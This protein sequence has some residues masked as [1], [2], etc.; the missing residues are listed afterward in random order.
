MFFL[1]SYSSWLPACRRLLLLLPALVLAADL[2]A[3]S[4]VKADIQLANNAVLAMY[5]DEDANMWIG[6]YDGLHL[7]NGKNTFVFRME[8]DNEFSLCSNIVLEI[9][10]AE[11]GYLWVTT[12]LGV[13]KFSL[14]ERHVVES[15][16]QYVDVE[17]IASDSEGN[18]VLFSGEDF[19][20][21][22][23]PQNAFFEDV[24]MP[25]VRAAEIVAVWSE[26]PREFCSLG[27]DGELVRYRLNDGEGK[28]FVR[29]SGRQLSARPVRKA[30]FKG[31]RLHFVDTSGGLWRYTGK[32]E[33]LVLLSD[34]S[35][36]GE[37]GYTASTVCSFGDEIYVGFLAGGLGRI[38]EKGG[39]CELIASDYRVFCLRADCNQD[40]LWVGTDGYGAYMYCDKKDPFTTLLMGDM[41]Q[42]VLK[43]V[44]AI[45]TDDRGDLWIGT[46]GDG[47][48]R[49]RD[50]ESYSGG[51]IPADRLTRFDRSKGLT[52]NEVFSFCSSPAR[53]I[54]W[55]GTS[56][57]GLTYYSY[58]DD[59]MRALPLQLGMQEP[60]SVHQMCE[61]NDSTLYLA[62]DT[63]ALVELTIDGGDRPF[64][65]AMRRYR[66]RHERHDCNEFYALIRESD[67]TLLLGMRG[68]YGLLRFNIRTKESEFVDMHRL[69]SRALGD[70]LCLCKSRESGLYCGASSGLILLTPQGD[71]RQ[72]DRRNG[73]VNDMIHGVLEDRHGCIWLSTN[74]GLVQY[75]PDHDFFHNYSS[76]DLRV[77]EFCDDA[78][79][80]CPRTGRLFF[81]GV[82]GVVWIDPASEVLADYKPRLRFMD[83]ELPDGTLVPLSGRTDDEKP[84]R[85]APHTT[86]FA[87]SF[88]AV[89]YLN[90][91]NYE[92]SY[93]LEGYSDKWVE[94]QKNNRVFFTGIPAGSYLLHVRYK[95]NVMDGTA[96]AYTLAITVLPPWYRTTAALVCYLLLAT[97]LVWLFV[98]LLRRHYRRQQQRVVARLEEVQREKLYEAR[99]NF[100]VN[101]SHEL[102]TPLTLINGMNE[103]IA[104]LGA[105]D[106]RLSK[107]TEV[108]HENV[109]GLNELIQEVLD[110]RKIEEEGFGR[111]RIR[112]VDIKA[113]LSVQVHS[114]TDA[115]ERNDIDLRLD[116]PPQLVWNTDA[117][118]LKKVVFNLVSNAMKYTPQRGRIGVSA[119]VDA[120][121][122]VLKV[123]N[124][125]RG[126]APA[127]LEHVF[128][129]YRI[130]DS[131]DRNMYTDSTSRNGLGLFICRGLVQ[132]LGGEISVS[133]EVDR[134]TEFTVRLPM[135]EVTADTADTEPAQK[136][137]ENNPALPAG[138]KPLVLVVDDNKDIVWL[139]ESALSDRFRITSYHSVADALD[140]LGEMTP[141]LIVTDIVMAGSCGLELVDTVRNDKFLRGIPIIVISAKIT[142]NEQVEGLVSGAD[143]YLTKP[144]SVPVLCATVE[145]LVANRRMLKEYYNTPESV[146]TVIEGQ[147]MHQTDKLFMEAVVETVQEH[148]Q[149]ENLRMELIAEH[150]G[151]T[152][153]NFYRKFKK[154][155]GRTP[156]EFIKE[157]R[158]EYAARLLTTTNLTVQEIM[159]RVGI[160]NKSYFY[161]E[162][163]KKYGLKPKEFRTKRE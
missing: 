149:S 146:Y 52:S 57:P 74:K 76:S 160:S 122:L 21:C 147:K 163:Q 50:Y 93:L 143:A 23:R 41:P 11:K 154:I 151:L 87:V 64:V 66:F 24:H 142:E 34:L 157:Y 107:Y 105:D 155:S 48:I 116:V 127:Q 91:D 4:L 40:I 158:F 53:N 58:K 100:F 136:I 36:L 10:P 121:S 128:D 19:I 92:Y 26:T 14:R 73:I 153:R 95:S 108:M 72:F 46:K 159:Y 144:F 49:I 88:V 83:L 161:R 133:S 32:D 35:Q 2:S 115:A 129:R 7:Y 126:I 112:S 96:Q 132:A 145:R 28:S 59:R 60:H 39:P 114:F 118:F 27:R 9:V 51:N 31:D 111:V 33:S 89:D 71:I 63:D 1:S 119:A 3:R 15:Y 43:P 106:P 67:S 42:K 30:F 139:I 141:D 69:Q 81:G 113:I 123:R 56:G 75:N 37:T 61:A 124:T 98:V 12:S 148:I 97:E 120:E 22:Y 137:S 17:N 20:A 62:C 130:L 18:T 80:R 54:L 44:R 16:M 110:F 131:M 90:G 109:V 150:L 94:L 138:E 5:Q 135:R 45:H 38:P 82:N 77:I 78:Y 162:F 117:A 134:Y 70:L 140:R 65:T 47:V 79:W 102:C 25:G 103:R 152:V 84:V 104:Q 101:I 85:I 99:L 8:L 156:S 29:I 86:G 13:N 125:G 6:T 55:L 68:G